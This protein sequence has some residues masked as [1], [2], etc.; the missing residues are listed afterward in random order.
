MSARRRSGHPDGDARPPGGL[1]NRARIALRIA[2]RSSLRARGRSALIVGLITIPVAGMAVL[3]LVMASTTPTTAEY[4]TV[5]LGRTQASV[6]VVA[7][8]D[9][10]VIQ[11]PRSTAWTNTPTDDAPESGESRRIDELVAPGTRLI[12]LLGGSA[13]VQ[14]ASGIAAVRTMLGETWDPALAGRYRLAEGHAPRAAGE[15]LATVGGLERLGIPVGGS[16]HLV[17]PADREATVVGVLDDLELPSSEPVL[18]GMPTSFGADTDLL[19]DPQTIAYLPDAT[20]SWA[21]VKALNDQGAVALSRAVQLHP[22]R[23][24]DYDGTTF[25]DRVNYTS[26]LL[27]GSIIIGFALLEVMLLAGAAFMVGARAQERSLATLASVGGARG[28]L[29]AVISSG[30]L[31]LGAIGGVLGVAV[32]VGLGTLFMAAT[33]DGSATRY[34]GFHLPLATLVWIALAAVAVG[35]LGALIP[36]VRASRIDVVAALRGA[37]R[38]SK[39]SIRRPIVGLV[40]LALGVLLTLG[41][42]ALSVAVSAANRYGPDHP[43]VWAMTGMLIGGPILAVLGLVLCSGLLLRLIARALSRAGVPARLASRDAAR[44]PSRSVPALAV[45]MTTVFVAVFAMT[46]IA[47]GEATAGAQYQYRLLPGQVGLSTSAT[48]PQ[49][50]TSKAVPGSELADAARA[51]LDGAK[52]RVLASVADPTFLSGERTTDPHALLPSLTVPAANQCP[53]DL[54]SVNYDES[55]TWGSSNSD[56]PAADWRCQSQVVL[57]GGTWSNAGRLWV[58]DADDLSL[59]L[60]RAPDAASR[61]TLENGGAV[62]FYPNYLEHG[63]VT[64]SWWPADHWDNA[65]PFDATAPASRSVAL[66]ATLVTPAHPLPYGALISRATADRLGLQYTDG[67]VLADPRTAPTRNQL[68]ALNARISAVTGFPDSFAS[69]VETGPPRAAGGFA[70]ALVGLSA[71]VAIAAAAIAIGLARADG[72]RDEN[73]LAAV[74]ASPRIRRGFG[75][76]QAVVLAGVGAVLGALV[77]LVPALA[78]T[79]PGS[80]TQ[81]SAPWLQIAVAATVLP[82]AIAC[83][84]WLA[85]GRRPTELRRAAIE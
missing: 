26:T 48:D 18:F 27:M 40:L 8:P 69:Y 34:W 17:A 7:P 56:A 59:M 76:W 41:G 12:P 84:S 78:L 75:F 80:A 46:M 66:K 83:A 70:W 9:S 22:P 63:S 45:I 31:I 85:L 82:L 58:G 53:A 3:T 68:D 15:I 54:N 71:L 74:G 36:A 4:L 28:T 65:Q 30:G 47:S 25:G 72:R 23:S 16:V 61:A 79:L 19:G 77:G 21:Q 14:T 37:R 42:G 38:P 39:P 43:I 13:T 49:T 60:G 50:G 81:F 32:G 24:T 62:S 52:V 5:Q 44:N 33:G 35:W 64:V 57:Y 55:M 2:R 29:I 51:S 6:Q 10:G 11:D 1:L 73:T 67:L 20:L